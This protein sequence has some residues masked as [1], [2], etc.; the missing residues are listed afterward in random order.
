MVTFRAALGKTA[1][2]YTIEH[3]SSHR[4]VIM[5]LDHRESLGADLHRQQP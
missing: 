2:G 3:V 5:D 1:R 4:L